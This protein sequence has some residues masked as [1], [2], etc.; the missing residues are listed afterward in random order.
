[1]VKRR[2]GEILQQLQVLDRIAKALSLS[3]YGK[4]GTHLE[5]KQGL[6]VV[7]CLVGR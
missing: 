1:M 5:T 6:A 2:K 7:K 4:G 3:F